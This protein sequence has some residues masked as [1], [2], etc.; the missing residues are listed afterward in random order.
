MIVS[1]YAKIAWGQAALR[2][3][4]TDAE[5]LERLLAG[6]RRECELRSVEERRVGGGLW[7]VWIGGWQRDRDLQE[8]YVLAL[9]STTAG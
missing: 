6:L 2:L 1:G 3:Y 8:A 7:G 9:R 4:C 5:A